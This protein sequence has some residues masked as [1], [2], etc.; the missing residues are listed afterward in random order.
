MIAKFQKFLGTKDKGRFCGRI[1]ICG[2]VGA[3]STL[4]CSSSY[5]FGLADNFALYSFICVSKSI[6][7]RK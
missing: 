3:I 5:V 2:A 6:L 7:L 1:G 4:L